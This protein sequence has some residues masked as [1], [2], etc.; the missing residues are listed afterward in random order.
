MPAPPTRTGTPPRPAISVINPL[1]IPAEPHGVVFFGRGDEI[2]QMMGADGQFL[3]RGLG[4]ADAQAAV[5]LPA[6]QAD[7]FER[8]VVR[9]GR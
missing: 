7:D 4:G 5:D 6:V 2:D 1:E 9:P 3:G 8:V